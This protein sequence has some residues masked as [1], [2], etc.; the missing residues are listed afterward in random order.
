M[1]KLTTIFHH[2]SF[3]Q[4]PF[5]ALSLYY[6]Y[7]PLF[8][9]MGEMWKDYNLGLTFLGIALSF[10]SFADLTKRNKLSRFIYGK[11]KLAKGFLIYAF[12]LFLI[13]FTFG[14]YSMFISKNENL[15]NLSTGIIVLG[16]GVLGLLR[17]TIELIQNHSDLRHRE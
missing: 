10:T 15:N 3:I 13:I 12:I 9:G 16:I 11:P 1:K 17:M 4:Y 6:V 7:K 2:M 8:D 5:L 14:M